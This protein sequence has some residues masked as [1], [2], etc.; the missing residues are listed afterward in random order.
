MFFRIES[1]LFSV[2]F[3]F[4]YLIHR[5]RSTQKSFF[6][7]TINV[8]FENEKKVIIKYYVFHAKT[9]ACSAWGGSVK[10]PAR[11]NFN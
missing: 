10:F 5:A 8:N 3:S 7:R 9:A 1:A 6:P 11:S 4:H 2:F